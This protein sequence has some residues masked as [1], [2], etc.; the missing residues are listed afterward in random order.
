MYKGSSNFDNNHKRIYRYNFIGTKLLHN[1]KDGWYVC[2]MWMTGI[3]MSYNLARMQC[4]LINP[5]SDL[6]LSRHGK[7]WFQL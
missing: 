4:A 3:L 7:S 1:E 2:K 6:L 5:K